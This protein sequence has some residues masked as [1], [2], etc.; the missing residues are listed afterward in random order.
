[1]HSCIYEGSVHHQ[2]LTP[3][4]H[5]FH[6]SVF[7]MYLDLAELDSVFDGRWLWSARRLA[8]ARFRR[9]DHL[10]APEAPLAD[11]IRA[12]VQDHLGA[13][14]EGPIRLLTHLRYFGYCFNPLSVY[15]CFDAAG[16]RLESVVLEVN[17]TP[18]GERHCYVLAV[19]NDS[20]ES[21]MHR[22]HFDKAFHVS[23]FLPMDMTYNVSANTPGESLRL[24]MADEQNGKTVLE[25]TLA[26]ERRPITRYALAR[27]LLK[28]P[29]MTGKV[30]LAIYGQALRLWCKN[31]PFIPRSVAPGPHSIGE[32]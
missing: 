17:N 31:I 23:P 30:I 3:K 5:A 29:F 20:S 11:C 13:R 24:F 19:P 32:I 1:M 15:Y 14:P 21:D 9:E 18:W 8:P 12:L 2:R 25:A 26:L 28:Y 10:G 27:V 7:M 6:Y 16:V 4:H 22:F